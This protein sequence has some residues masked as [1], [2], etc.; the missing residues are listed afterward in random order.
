MKKEKKKEIT[1]FFRPEKNL[2]QHFGVFL[3]VCF[4]CVGFACFIFASFQQL[5]HPV[6]M[7]VDRH[8]LVLLMPLFIIPQNALWL[9]G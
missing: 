7:V 9:L 3:L 1:P 6:G 8:F 2:C 5:D 4:L